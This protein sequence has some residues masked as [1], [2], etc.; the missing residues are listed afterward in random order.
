MARLDDS[1]R[2]LGAALVYAAMPPASSW[3]SHVFEW[4]PTIVAAIE[5]G[6]I[7]AGERSVEALDA[8]INAPGADRALGNVTPSKE[9]IDDHLQLLATFINDE[10]WCLLQE[11]ELGLTD[12]QLLRNTD[13][14]QARIWPWRVTVEGVAKLRVDPRIVS[15]VL[16][17]LVYKQVSGVIIQTKERAEGDDKPQ[18]LTLSLSSEE[19]IFSLDG[20]DEHMLPESIT[21]QRLRRLESAGQGFM[22]ILVVEEG[23]RGTGNIDTEQRRE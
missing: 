4:Q 12:V 21:L 11:Q 17:T 20:H 16:R 23:V 7:S 8:F 15:L 14:A 2:E 19:S 10:Q 1:A 18:R 3:Q 6:V 22:E 9:K 5:N 13:A